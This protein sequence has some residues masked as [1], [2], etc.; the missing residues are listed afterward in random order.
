MTTHPSRFVRGAFARTFTTIG[1]CRPCGK[2]IHLSR[3]AAR[4]VAKAHHRG[5][6]RRPYR[7]PVYL[8]HWH[9]GELAPAVVSGR[10]SR[11]EAYPS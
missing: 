6:D 3:K 5:E 10:I 7:C 1:M 8:D 2:A 4:H 11:Q 9:L